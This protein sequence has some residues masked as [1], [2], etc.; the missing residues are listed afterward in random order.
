MKKKANQGTLV[1]ELTHDGIPDSDLQPEEFDEYQLTVLNELD[2]NIQASVRKGC[3]IK[4]V[5]FATGQDIASF[6]MK[7]VV[8]SKEQE[9][10]LIKDLYD[11]MM[12]YMSDPENI[13]KIKKRA[14]QL[15]QQ[16]DK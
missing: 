5:D 14:E 4:V 13:A 8:L 3:P 7:N 11:A 10:L 16:N 2:E 6:N 15:K 1:L 12:R 9:K